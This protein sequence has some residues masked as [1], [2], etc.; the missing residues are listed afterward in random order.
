MSNVME[1]VHYVG[2][3]IENAKLKLNRS[4]QSILANWKLRTFCK[5]QYFKYS[6][7]SGKIMFWER[8][9]TPC[10]NRHE[11]D[12]HIYLPFLLGRSTSMFTSV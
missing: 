7:H 10:I 11:W 6:H 2:V 9:E 4:P 8:Q 3:K 12:M 1:I 5:K